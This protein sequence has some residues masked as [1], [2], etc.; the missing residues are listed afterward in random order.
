MNPV[1]PGTQVAGRYRVERTLGTGGM[2]V[3]VEATHLQLAQRVAIKFLLPELCSQRDSVTRFLR[4]ARAAVRIESEHVARVMD[5]GTSDEGVPFLV[6]EYLEGL[7]LAQLLQR[8]QRLPFAQA[9][10]LIVQAADAIA[11][12][13]SLGII[14][15]DL[16][17]SNLFL[18][19]RRDGTKS[20]KVLDFGISKAVAEASSSGLATRTAT[21]TVMGSPHYMSPEQVRSSKDV[22]PRADIWS[23]GVILH[24]LLAG[25]PP[26]RAETLP[27]VLASIV[28]DPP[29]SLRASR[30]DVPSALEAVVA[31]CLQKDRSQRYATVPELSRALSALT[32]S[33]AQPAL[34]RIQSFD[35]PLVAT[36]ALG[37]LPAAG[38]PLPASDTQRGFARALG[39]HQER[40]VGLLL[41]GLLGVLAATFG[42]LGYRSEQA[43]LP[44]AAA[45]AS[46]SAA[47]QAPEP[48]LATDAPIAP[49]RWETLELSRGASAKPAPAGTSLT[50]DR[51]FVDRH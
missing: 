21:A 37:P 42:Y 20:L 49:S 24:E 32:P 26:F 10:S 34:L 43:P 14:H 22:D 17:P 36:R 7:D 44:S 5:V 28:A 23:L 33:E 9:V 30:P 47:L 15:R 40:R 51:L 48:P 6:M 39:P 2:G 8:E 11:E 25:E 12:A 50:D 16:K 45:S 18:A 46:S 13:H 38:P 4:E 31:R 19:T 29:A 1:A 41:A 35:K 3:V 27:G